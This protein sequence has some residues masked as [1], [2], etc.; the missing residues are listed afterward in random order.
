VAVNNGFTRE[1][2]CGETNNGFTS[3]NGQSIAPFAD[4]KIAVVQIATVGSVGNNLEMV[5]VQMEGMELVAIVVNRPFVDAADLSYKT[6]GIGGA[7]W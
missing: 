2:A 3:E 4:I 5:H 7:R 1:I 6:E